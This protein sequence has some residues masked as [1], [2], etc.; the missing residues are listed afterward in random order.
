MSK[1]PMTVICGPTACGKTPA[2]IHLAQ[3]LGGEIISA[4]SMQIYKKMDIGTAK[5][6]QEEMRG[7]VHH[8]VDE[9]APDEEYSVAIFKNKAAQLV[10]EINSRG[11]MPIICGGTGF[12]LNA[13]LYD[14]EFEVEP[15][16]DREYRQYLEDMAKEKGVQHLHD[17]LAKIDPQAAKLTDVGNMKRVIRAIEYFHKHNAPISLHN[18]QQ[19]E[20]RK[21]PVYSDAQVFVLCGERA[22]MYDRINRRVDA[23]VANGL[24]EEV[25]AL[26]EAGY[27]PALTS[28]QGIGYKEIVK[29]LQNECTLEEAITTVKRGTRHFA[30]RQLTWFRHQMAGLNVTWVDIDEFGDNAAIGEEIYRMCK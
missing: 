18:K 21:E 8:L 26:L 12:Y 20:K 6:T 7:I 22:E 11:K 25:T 13:L 14:I 4:D 19:K 24:V 30:K 29:Y 9:L 16:N 23:M 1:T 28:M 3:K 15:D 2:A 27:S 5:V 17:M 10:N